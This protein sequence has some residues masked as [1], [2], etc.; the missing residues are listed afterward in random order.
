MKQINHQKGFTLVELMVTIIILSILA[1]IAYPNL[2]RYIQRARM[3]NAR[4]DM[5]N[6]I[7]EMEREYANKGKFSSNLPTGVKV[8][9]AS[10]KYNVMLGSANSSRFIL[11]AEPVAGTYDAST[12]SGTP[13]NL[14]YDSATAAFARCNTAGFNVAKQITVDK[15]QSSASTDKNC[16]IF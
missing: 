9:T 2:T 10:H 12:L 16:E 4:A 11:W 7:K 6:I 3:E 1:A 13:L 15:T 14:L 8:D 5:T